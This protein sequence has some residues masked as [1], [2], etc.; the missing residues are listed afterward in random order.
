MI[1]P[2]DKQW[3]EANHVCRRCGRMIATPER[4]TVRELRQAGWR[5]AYDPS[6]GVIAV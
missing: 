2:E 6:L 4:T 3:L 5:V 1:K